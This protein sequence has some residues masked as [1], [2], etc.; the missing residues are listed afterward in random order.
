MDTQ[1]AET[2]RNLLKIVDKKG[3]VDNKLDKI[4]ALICNANENNAWEI[5][6]NLREIIY[7]KST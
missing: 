7:K 5:I 6:K 3:K 2:V 1:Q 4:Q